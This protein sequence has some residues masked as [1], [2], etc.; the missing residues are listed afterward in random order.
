M[1]LPAAL[2]SVALIVLVGATAQ[3][4]SAETVK[5][6]KHVKVLANESA[7]WSN[8]EIQHAFHTRH[9]GLMACLRL[10]YDP[11]TEGQLEYLIE[12]ND[13]Q[14]TIK[15]LHGPIFGTAM[16]APV[17]SCMSKALEG[18]V[19]GKPWNRPGTKGFNV[20]LKV[21]RS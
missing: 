10:G 20:T 16:N 7:W 21:L 8:D 15:A 9:D 18:A 2:A 5:D 4:A 6:A 14:G 13:K 3:D 19:L 1:R 12:V 17:L 11:H